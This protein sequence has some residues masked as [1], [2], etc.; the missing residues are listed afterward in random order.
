MRLPVDARMLADRSAPLASAAIYTKGE[1]DREFVRLPT[2]L[3]DDGRFLEAQVSHFSEFEGGT[4]PPPPA[5]PLACGVP[6]LDASTGCGFQTVVGDVTG[7]FVGSFRV[8]SERK[9]MLALQLHQRADGS[10]VGYVLGGTHA[11]T[12]VTGCRSGTDVGLQ[13]ELGDTF[14][15][16]TFDV[17]ANLAH[18]DHLF[19]SADD[20]DPAGPQSI[21]LDRRASDASVMTERRFVFYEGA[22]LGEAVNPVEVA[23]VT[24]DDL[25]FPATGGFVS[26]DDV[27]VF[28]NAG[29]V[30]SFTQSFV[31]GGADQA[32]TI[33]LGLETGGA[34]P[35]FGSVEASF[36]PLI[37][38]YAGTYD[39]TDCQGQRSGPV[40][41]KR[42]TR[43][44]SDHV[45]GVLA[46]L[47]WLGDAI[48]TGAPDLGTRLSP[49]YL[50]YGAHGPTRI[51]ELD[52]DA[53]QFGA[54]RVAIG[55]V[56]DLVTVHD[57]FVYADLDAPFGVE[58]HDR[59]SGIAEGLGE[60]VYRDVDG[61][62]SD[63]P[64]DSTKWK[65]LRVE[66]GTWKFYGNQVAAPLEDGDAGANVCRACLSTHCTAPFQA[67]LADGTCLG[68]MGQ[69][70]PCTESGV[71]MDQCMSVLAGA[72]P[73]GAAIALC[74]E[75]TCAPE[76]A[77]GAG[78][79]VDQDAGAD[80]GS[81][82]PCD[83]C[84]F[85]SCA[86]EV[87][88]CLADPACS[89]GPNGGL[90][91]CADDGGT[92]ASCWAEWGAS[93][94]VAS[95]VLACVEANCAGLC[96]IAAGDAGTDRDD[97]STP[98]DM[99]VGATIDDGNPCTEDACDPA[100]G[101][102]HLPTSAGAA[103]S[104]GDVCNGIET[105]DGA[106][107]CE[108]GTPLVVDDDNFC[109]TDTCDPIAGVA[110]APIAACD[111]TPITSGQPFETRAS[112]L[113]RVVDAAGAPLTGY[114]VRVFDAPAIGSPRSDLAVR[115]APDGSFR[116]RLTSFPDAEPEHT[117]PRRVVV[118]V[119]APGYVR[120]IREAY[121]HPGTALNLGTV[122]VFAAD[123]Q[124][125]VIDAAGGVAM[126][127]QGL[128]EIHFPPGAVTQP[129]PVRI[130]PLP[131][132]ELLPLPLPNA[133]MTA[134]AFDVQPDGVQLGAA[135][136]VRVHNWRNLPTSLVIPAGYVD[137]RQAEWTHVGFAHWDG[138]AF[139]FET[140]HFSAWDV[141]QG[142]ANVLVMVMNKPFQASNAAKQCGGS[143]VGLADGD[144]QQR[145]ELPSY[146]SLGNT[147]GVTLVY[148]SAQAAADTTHGTPAG[149]IVPGTTTSLGVATSSG[150]V[151]SGGAGS[152][153]TSCV[154]GSAAAAMGGC[155]LGGCGGNVKSL[156]L[157]TLSI[158]RSGAAT[159]SQ[160]DVPEG[161]TE[162]EIPSD[163][164][165]PLTDDGQLA[166]S[167]YQQTT[168]T[169]ERSPLGTTAS[170]ASSGEAFGVGGGVQT[171]NVPGNY[172]V[173]ALAVFELPTFVHTRH[174]SPFGAG[175][176]VDGIDRVY[177]YNHG[178]EMTL[179]H[180]SGEQERFVPRPE[181]SRFDATETAFQG[182]GLARDHLTATT[183]IAKPN[184]TI[185]SYAADG[186]IQPV[187]SGLDFGG[188]V[189]ALAITRIAGDRHFV[190]AGGSAVW[191]VDGFGVARAI[192]FPSANVYP[193]PVYAQ[194]HVAASGEWVYYTDGARGAD[195]SHRI[196]TL[197]YAA[198]L[199][200]PSPTLAP[201]SALS[202]DATLDPVATLQ[203][204]QFGAPEG[205][206]IAPDGSLYV[207]DEQ[208][209]CLYAAV[210]DATGAVTTD[211]QVRRVLGTGFARSI[212]AL[213]LRMPARGFEVFSPVDV[214]VADDGTVFVETL[215]GIAT[216]DPLATEASW[217]A[218]GHRVAGSVLPAD[219]I[220]WV[221]GL[222]AEGDA[223][224]VLTRTGDGVTRVS[225]HGMT[226]TSDP[227]RVFTKTATGYTLDDAGA[228]VTE[229]YDAA[230]RIVARRRRT[231][232]P[233]L[234]VQWADPQ[235]DRIAAI[236]DAA[237]RATT[238]TYGNG[239]KISEIRDAVTR[240]TMVD[241]DAQ[242]DLRTISDPS[243]QVWGFD[244]LGHRMVQ[245]TSP[246]Q[247]QTTYTY[248]TDGMLS[249]TQKPAGEGVHIEPALR[250]PGRYDDSGH[251]LRQAAFT[252]LH[253]VPHTMT[254]DDE[255]QV[256]KDEWEVDGT[257]YTR[258]V[259]YAPEL[260]PY[261]IGGA[262]GLTNYANDMRRVAYTTLN[263]V[264]V[265]EYKYYDARA[266]L[267][268][269]AL[270]PNNQG[271]RGSLGLDA[272]G[273]VTSY[274]D[275]GGITHLVDRD[276][277]GHMLGVHEQS[278]RA[279]LGLT[280]RTDGQL[281]TSTQHNVTTTF[282][283]VN[284]VLGGE[285]DTTGRSVA[286]GF[287]P[288]GNLT[289]WGDGVESR[290]YEHDA[291]NRLLAA[292]DGYGNRTTF[293]YT[294][295]PCG[296][297][298]ADRVTSIRTPGLPADAAWRFGYAPEGRVSSITDPD[299]H[300]QQIEY[301]P[302]GEVK[303]II[304]GLNRPSLMTYDAMGRLRTAVDT[305]GRAHA[306]AHP[307]ASA[308]LWTGAEVLAG[309]GD[310]QPP[311]T[312]LTA[313]LASGQYQVGLAG[314]QTVGRPARI[315]L[316]RDATFELSFGRSFNGFDA[317][318]ERRDRTG[319]AI[320]SG[321]IFGSTNTGHNEQFS[322]LRPGLPSGSTSFPP[323]AGYSLFERAYDTQ[324][325]L[326]RASS[327][328]AEYVYGRDTAGRVTSVQRT[329]WADRSRPDTGSTYG[330]DPSG[331]IETVANVDG[332]H[333][334]TYDL[335]GSVAS[336]TAPEGTYVY[337]YDVA[338]QNE[339]LTYPSGLRREQTFDYEGRVTSRC[340]KYAGEADRC[341]GVTYDAAGNPVTL[342]DPEG[343]DTVEYDAVDRVSR[344]T[345]HVSGQAD[346]VEE[347]AYND[348]GALVVNAGVVLDD[349]RPKL[350]GGG[351]A[352][353][354]VPASFGG[355]A[356]SLDAVGRINALAGATFGWSQRSRLQ[357][358]GDASGSESYGL[359]TEYRRVL[360]TP[361]SGPIESYVYEGWNR[362]GVL[363]AGG[364]VETY[365]YDAVDHPLRFRRAATQT[366]P[367]V[368]AY[369]EVDCVGNVRRLRAPSGA[370]LGGYRYTAFGVS[371]ED[372]ATA[373]VDQPLRWKARPYSPYA[374][375]I[376][377]MRAR[378]WSPAIGAFLS[379]DEFRYLGTSGTLWSWPGQNP[380]KWSDPSGR[381]GVFGWA[382]VH[383]SPIPAP[384][385]GILEAVFVAGYD[386]QEGA[387]VADIFGA[388]AEANAVVLGG[389]YV[390]GSETSISSSGPHS[391]S[392]ELADVS[393]GPVIVGVFRT[394]AG[395]RGIYV[396]GQGG[397]FGEHAAL[398]VGI[399]FPTL[400]ER[401]HA[402]VACSR[403]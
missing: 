301:E 353:A 250:G 299:G 369:Y 336:V 315:E 398:G 264:Q 342:T 150:V 137:Q 362:V 75:V 370:D 112:L 176:Y 346:V 381:A 269:W 380:Y 142:D 35:G 68:A 273:R 263:G 58:F 354:A 238:F 154:S 295:L 104:D 77:L 151:G 20:G 29:G 321:T 212:H 6:P 168:V 320:T 196:D 244:Y 52:Y 347:Y 391:Q 191:D 379:A 188:Q 69:L 145:I 185:G 247:E 303:K 387:Y 73:R 291:A 46:S 80:G 128:V 232:E 100:S 157:E 279:E 371:V 62:S 91:A 97:G 162:I 96:P 173:G 335:R 114:D 393:I 241:V 276:V 260:N 227:T 160:L 113:G 399:E 109:T 367:E 375:G 3:S 74:A 218:L 325:D 236:V 345:R 237:N 7:T 94:P 28:G 117:P 374:G 395:A 282:H 328:D 61:T 228:D 297:S 330:Y 178:G 76:C 225:V 143:S 144:L 131:E 309:S 83:A 200:D 34:C 312:D 123:S 233:I 253:G 187:V 38:L 193:A 377:D 372:T 401:G 258:A 163:S 294:Q 79:E 242:G 82:N 256:S 292:M 36:D 403:R 215:F 110:H 350:N 262:D 344:V 283:Y 351:T 135:A 16:R 199:T 275:E 357:S 190:V 71:S 274:V 246:S 358:V 203:G 134:Y 339:L 172:S 327:A 221:Q 4:E 252:D 194:P 210:P 300:V 149:S 277:A 103:C 288:A 287:D 392:I 122:K 107:A 158:L 92:I 226:S 316:Y 169:V 217:F 99:C 195:S 57:P 240:T 72:G 48:E 216:F 231:G 133:T 302:T 50:H 389:S 17:C 265:D 313:P 146:Q 59:R 180:G 361:S 268:R 290:F 360:K 130:T 9:R 207:A 12:V 352:D 141:N 11:R 356:I 54:R 116:A 248:G 66:D 53:T 382:S 78:P 171:N 289:A 373:N 81:G 319:L 140:T 272:D 224:T 84:M 25:D 341:Y 332:T 49:S 364:R 281:A 170:C 177:A 402:S 65:Y 87:S 192:A 261:S 147:Y 280:W 286:Y 181:L 179:V 204:V 324:L 270:G 126:D 189:F 14:G 278:G 285:S 22:T 1:G 383:W 175:W 51:T 366:E 161:A 363:P 129:T 298:E 88:T 222:A 388:G 245:K 334:Y 164:P 385:T 348:I 343:S 251:I 239:G 30:T 159:V 19:G 120:A 5:V 93:S 10:V 153:T 67:C 368:V 95:G 394:G 376:Y 255:G 13:I 201:I 165:I 8:G 115:Y 198:R 338:G 156:D 317:V 378:Q 400:V 60:V 386:G 132:R 337:G 42:G 308:G 90:Q 211:S 127:S 266:R 220:P 15:T 121:L 206:A 41:G 306:A 24:A 26:L 223:S 205:L 230:G 243:Q 329:F 259:V 102:I 31:D 108:P 63:A 311:P 111:P 365:L 213:G 183:F 318:T 340:Y 2:T 101:V 136:T 249:S 98:T 166:A 43:T 304:D 106:G 18:D 209:H 86:T 186:S 37:G 314:F 202:G 89:A 124:V 296:C 184:G 384:V 32:T 307:T 197:V 174:G 55:R 333:T 33:R 21:T 182:V 105:C 40:V 293:G 235:S 271:V 167:G 326:Q 349:Q 396:G 138:S 214:A 70:G 27:G 23:V 64:D 310:A 45:A 148:D 47:G 305:L 257:A 56:R 323:G 125:T 155:V 208:R 118:Y 219:F 397:A 355:Q 234:S 85:A 39:F 152:I 119:E 254:L 267:V 44:R 284:G 359:D 331:R 390:S 229:D 322:W 139:A